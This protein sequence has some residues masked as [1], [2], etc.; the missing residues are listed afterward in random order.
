MRLE[1]VHRSFLYMEI[2]SANG[3]KWA[4]TAVY[5][6]PKASVRQ[7]LWRK[8]YELMV[9]IPWILIGEFNC[10]L[11]TEERSSRTGVSSSFRSRVD[12]NGLIDRGLTSSCY[13]WSHGSSVEMR[14]AAR[15][16]RIICTNEWR[17]R[18]PG[19]SV[20]HL[21][22]AYSDHCLVLLDLNRVSGCRMG[23]RPFRF[24]ASWMSHEKF[25]QWM[26]RERVW[27]VDLTCSLKCFTKNYWHGIQIH[28]ETFLGERSECKGGWRV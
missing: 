16:D 17:R 23:E 21:S 4:L 12:K 5:A 15:L 9:G 3:Q 1:V 26:E 2:R 11:L 18:F 22:H 24:L 8:L 14:R 27:N 13:T 7:F 28:L 6:N 20:R 19:A 25:L 10:A